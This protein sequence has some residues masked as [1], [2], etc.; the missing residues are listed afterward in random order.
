[1]EMD[2]YVG[3]SLE[4]VVEL[5][6]V[7]FFINIKFIDNNYLPTPVE[8]PYSIFFSKEELEM[9]VEITLAKWIIDKGKTEILVW[10]KNVDNKLIVF[11]SQKNRTEKK[12]NSRVI[13]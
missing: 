2:T 3:M 13:L 1:M 11:T 9:G 12:S 4:Q 10:I 8:P 7:P 5:L 6:G